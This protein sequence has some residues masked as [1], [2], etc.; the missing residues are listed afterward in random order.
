MYSEHLESARILKLDHFGYI[1]LISEDFYFSRFFLLDIQKHNE[2]VEF[3]KK[4]RVL[5]L[6]FIQPEELITYESFYKRL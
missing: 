1:N 3:I 6:D 2:V 4:I 5:Y